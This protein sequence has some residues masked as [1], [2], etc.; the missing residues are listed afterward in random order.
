MFSLIG[1]A[2][3]VIGGSGGI[4]SEV[5]R[6]LTE[7]GATVAFTYLR[8]EERA[9]ILSSEIAGRHSGRV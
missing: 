6:G 7:Q 2:C 8:H 4:G 9:R 1:K 3:L 5:V